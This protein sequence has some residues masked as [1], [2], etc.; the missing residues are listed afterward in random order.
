MIPKTFSV[1]L[2]GLALALVTGCGVSGHR[3]TMATNSKPAPARWQLPDLEH[4]GRQTS[5]VGIFNHD[6]G[7]PRLVML[8]SPT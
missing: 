1:L 2:S 4:G 8:V 6:V 5:L 7:T 3:P